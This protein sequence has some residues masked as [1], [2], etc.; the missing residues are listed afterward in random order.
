LLAEVS[1]N[2]G[3]IESAEKELSRATDLGVVSRSAVSMHYRILLAKGK[4]ADVLAE[5]GQ[6][7]N[8][9]E[10]ADISLYRGQA[11]LGLGSYAPAE[12]VFRD[13]LEREP[14]SVEARM[15]LASALGAQSLWEDA[16]ASLNS[17]L[18]ESPSDVAAL[19]ALATID[20]ASKSYESAENGFKQ[21]LANSDSE[22]NLARHVK[23]LASLAETQL[24][25]RKVDDAERT[26]MTMQGVAPTAPSTL[27]LLARIATE[28]KNYGEAMVH[29]QKLLQM[30]PDNPRIQLALAVAHIQE[31]NLGQA[32]GLLTRVVAT[33]PDN[34][35]ARKLL[36]QVQL[37]QAKP[38]GA[39]EA[40]APL[41][42]DDNLD[43]DALSL[44]ALANLRIGNNAEAAENLI[45][46]SES[47][48]DNIDRKLDLA[49]FYLG[50]GDH[51]KAM[52]LLVT[53]PTDEDRGLR[54]SRL[55]VV[56]LL[57]SGKSDEAQL[58]VRELVSRNQADPEVLNFA[59]SYYL[60]V[61]DNNSARSSFEAG[62]AT[63][64]DN[65]SLLLSLAG[66][67]AREGEHAESKLL[68]D[69]VLEIDKGNLVASMAAAALA[70][71]QGELDEAKHYLNSS[72]KVYPNAPEL[73]VSLANILLQEGN[74][75]DAL[76][77]ARETANLGV[78]NPRLNG[79]L[80]NVMLATGALEE[81]LVQ[82][83]KSVADSPESPQAQ[84]NLARGLLAL[85]R[86]VP[87]KQ[88]LQKALEVQPDWLQ[89]RIALVLVNLRQGLVDQALVQTGELRAAHPDNLQ[90][91]VLEGEIYFR[92]KDFIK[93]AD[94]FNLA[95]ASGAGR[96]ALLREFQ[97]LQGA[98]VS[99]PIK[100][101]VKWL[102][103]N[104]DDTQVRLF[105]AQYHQ[106]AGDPSEAT[107]AYE[108]ILSVEPNNAVA[109]NNL[110]WEYQKNGNLDDALKLAKK[111][112]EIDSNSGSIADTLAWI[113]RERGELEESA[114]LLREANRLSP[115]NADISY[116]LAAV[117]VQS[118]NKAEA[119]RILE[120]VLSDE[121]EFSSKAEA[122]KLLQNL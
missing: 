82:F 58:K 109:L 71:E 20:F 79:V 2:L 77:L 9:L 101:L 110:A 39:I 59:G 30:A 33:A 25:L 105:V 13:W 19:Q 80:G 52:D 122:E 21:A 114:S 89:A 31:G 47:D 70:M 67:Q 63:S 93:A 74:K 95:V 96:S 119:R 44:L 34:L 115:A 99:D 56:G 61:G 48:P 14:N 54:V 49:E 17:V 16:R 121:R 85:D 69:Q 45:A 26:V 91:M 50:T 62:I 81:A 18:S 41:L 7:A 73:K 113:L 116:H 78:R 97:S 104:P 100:P 8:N 53:L 42:E 72:I 84:F 88:A 102:E 11:L 6:G 120:Q 27:F 108:A 12:K 23:I 112:Y 36:A 87:A 86:T 83:E 118:G 92:Q 24:I 66:L 15:G 65:V 117:L 55:M 90:V 28:R 68:F 106:M 3:D 5:L 10:E 38:Q 51:K 4:F 43:T 111:A 1:L 64:P 32:E 76:D 22:S 29:L 103:K 35:Y 40:L 107:L 46:A 60:A 57:A 98:G 75:D 94:V 37:S